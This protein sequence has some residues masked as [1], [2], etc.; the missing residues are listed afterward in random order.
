V[1]IASDT[2][3]S[4]ADPIN[5]LKDVSLKLHQET[6]GI[7]VKFNCVVFEDDVQERATK[8][9]FQFTDHCTPSKL[10]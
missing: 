5:N 6:A 10:T 1:M 3:S 4:E 7:E 2:S 8:R 9:F